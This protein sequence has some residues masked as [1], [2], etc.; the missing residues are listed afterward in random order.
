MSPAPSPPPRRDGPPGP[1]PPPRGQPARPGQKRDE[2]Q[3]P[4]ERGDLLPQSGS[5]LQRAGKHF[6]IRKGKSGNPGEEDEE[7]AAPAIVALPRSITQEQEEAD[8]KRRLNREELLDINK[9]HSSVRMI[10]AANAPTPL[11]K[12][13]SGIWFLVVV[14]VLAALAVLADKF[15]LK[16]LILKPH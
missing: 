2:D 3:H 13:S 15:H 5:G 12:R 10:G 9:R 16:E 11:R 8:L 6:E 1:K 4:A 14:L 7:E